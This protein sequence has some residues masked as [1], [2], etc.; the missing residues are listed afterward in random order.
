M[1]RTI[2]DFPVPQTPISRA[3]GTQFNNVIISAISP[4]RGLI[5]QGEPADNPIATSNLG[6]PVY[7]DLTF[8]GGTYTDDAGNEIE[9]NTLN[10]QTVLMLV[11]QQKNIVTTQ[12]AGRD[13]TI[14]EYIG[15]DD[16]R[17]T[18]QGIITGS[19]NVYPEDAVTSF[20]DILNAPVPI[21]VTSNYLTYF[22]ITNVVVADYAFPQV[23]GVNSY[24]PFTLTLLSDNT[25]DFVI[26]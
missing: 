16:Y 15:L 25:S 19:N 8:D 5:P 7:A 21:A 3:F 4:Y 11:E 20:I 10:F 23:E 26:L 9:L 12:I 14:K 18:V 17:I 2:Y 1:A 24:Q 6:T 13:G 22:G